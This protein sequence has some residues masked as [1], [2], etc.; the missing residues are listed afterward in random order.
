MG[1]SS[2]EIFVPEKTYHWA[3]SFDRAGSDVVLYHYE[4]KPLKKV[5]RKAGFHVG[6]G[7]FSDL[8]FLDAKSRGLT[9]GAGIR[10]RTHPCIRFSQRHVCNG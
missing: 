4:S 1:K 9:S 10:T 3:F 8:T 5:L 6:Q 7:S 2:A